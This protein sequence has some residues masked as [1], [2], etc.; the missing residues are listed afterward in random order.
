MNQ[1]FHKF[2]LL[3]IFLL[4]LTAVLTA[5][6]ASAQGDTRIFLQPV[7]DSGDTV[8]VDVIAENV[9]ELYGVEFLLTYDPAAIEVVDVRPEQDGVQINAGVLLPA[10]Q[11]FVVANQAN[12]E[13]GTIS[14]AMTLLNPAP[15]VS[16]SGSLAQ[17]NLKK[18]QT[19]PTTID[20]ADV[21]LVAVSL[22]IIPAQTSGLTL[23]SAD[24][25][26]L[27]APPAAASNAQA[28]TFPWWIVAIGIIVVGLITLGAFLVLGNLSGNR[29]PAAPASTQHSTRSRPSAFK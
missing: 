20:V 18:L 21:K 27:N 24:S 19:A 12:P 10:D 28:S 5:A 23:N 16:G 4:L 22:Q 9:T 2:G 29:P 15:A 6:P 17:L 26:A 14:F 8:T 25:G 13:N 3:K 7:S 1:L 11:G